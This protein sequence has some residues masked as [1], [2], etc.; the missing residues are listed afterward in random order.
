MEMNQPCL[1]SGDNVRDVQC[2]MQSGMPICNLQHGLFTR[3]TACTTMIP[4]MASHQ[5]RAHLS[6]R[7]G[8][9][10]M[11]LAANRP[12]A[13]GRKKDRRLHP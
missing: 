7:I 5:M 9:P 4:A 10:L 12:R 2:N 13:R 6:T 3:N 1:F 8:C 11:A